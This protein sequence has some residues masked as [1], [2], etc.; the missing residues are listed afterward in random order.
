MS[1]PSNDGNF[2][3]LTPNSDYFR[4]T[5]GFLNP[6][7]IGLRAL[8][9]ND[10]VIGSVSPELIDG[11]R[12]EDLLFGGSGNDIL[13]GGQGTDLL[14]GGQGSDLLISDEGDDILIGDLDGDTL[15]GGSGND[16]FVLR[17]DL[18]AAAVDRITDFDP[19]FDGIGLTDN[20]SEADLNLEP[21][22]GGTLIKV[23][24]N[25]N[26]LGQVANVSPAQLRGHFVSSTDIVLD[27]NLNNPKN[28]GTLSNSIGVNDFV[29]EDDFQDIYTFTIDTPSTI[30]LELNGLSADADLFL[31]R[32]AN[33][34]GSLSRDEISASRNLGTLPEVIENRFFVP[35]QY[36]VYVQQGVRGANTNYHLDINVKP[37]Q[38]LLNQ[39][40]P[41]LVGA[42][43]GEIKYSLDDV[44]YEKQPAKLYK[45]DLPQSSNLQVN[46]RGMYPG[47]DADL[48]LFQ[49]VNKNNKVDFGEILGVP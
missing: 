12:G 16:L 37:I 9:G 15:A 20:L 47:T 44:V 18:N 42:F 13:I 28:L 23:R 26:I 4:L 32:D 34:D 14:R 17:T 43:S 46:L 24:G 2:F 49:D 7:T 36:F 35:S 6:F 30:K 39:V 33:R 5:P 19:R 25:N 10:T 22:A 45:F 48:V 27:D 40:T 8:E 11:G 31:A 29:G 3:D 41:Q 38:F 21:L 1:G